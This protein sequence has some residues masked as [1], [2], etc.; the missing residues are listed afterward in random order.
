MPIPNSIQ[1]IHIV[2]AIKDV[3]KEGPIKTRSSTEYVML[4]EGVALEPKRVISRAAF[5]AIGRELLPSDFSGGAESNKF[6]NSRG[7]QV[8]KGATK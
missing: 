5:Y 7:F 1:A 6:L 8:V 3:K 4:V 2:K